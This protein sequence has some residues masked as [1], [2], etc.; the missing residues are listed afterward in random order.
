[1]GRDAEVVQCDRED[2][3][4]SRLA[5]ERDCFLADSKDLSGRSTPLEFAADTTEL[6]C[7]DRRRCRRPD[8]L[9]AG[10]ARLEQADGLVVVLLGSQV[11]RAGEQ[12]RANLR[13]LIRA[14]VERP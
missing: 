8:R 6:G 2:E 14:R 13:W 11:A 7:C 5:R 10:K 4:V 12:P 9:R 1:M 3:L